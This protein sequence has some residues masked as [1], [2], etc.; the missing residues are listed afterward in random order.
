MSLWPDETLARTVKAE[1]RKRTK[2]V[3]AR[4]SPEQHRSESDALCA[5]VLSSTAF[6]AARSLGLYVPHV[7][8]RE[9]DVWAIARAAWEAGKEVAMPRWPIDLSGMQFARVTSE[10]DT[11]ED[12]RGWGAAR[13]DAPEATPELILVPGLLFDDQGRRL[14][15]G[16]GLYDGY[17]RGRA[18]RGPGAATSLAAPPVAL[19]VCFD[20]QLAV[21]LP[22]SPGDVRVDGVITNQRELRIGR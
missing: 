14:G 1:L 2:A 22:E 8:Y 13:S 18:E 10:S 16:A 12:A 20:F 11:A 21:E 9:L 15:Y 17:L 3:R 19:G 4:M 7:A 5:R 6:I